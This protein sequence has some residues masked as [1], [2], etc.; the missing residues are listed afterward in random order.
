MACSQY[1]YD[2]W[3]YFSDG[4]QYFCDGWRARALS[5]SPL[6]QEIIKAPGGKDSVYCI[7]ISLANHND[8]ITGDKRFSG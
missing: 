2:G 1:I 7:E 4:W 6:P 3:Q 8:I 5:R